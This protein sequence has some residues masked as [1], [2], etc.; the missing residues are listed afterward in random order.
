MSQTVL[1]TGGLG[2]IGLAVGAAFARQGD[3]LVLLDSNTKRAAQV[4]A[5][6]GERV[7]ILPTDVR[8]AGQV[9]SAVA[10]TL[11]KFG[12]I[13]YLV[14]CAGV[15]RWTPT[16]ELSEEEWD[17]VLDINLKG[18]FLVCREVG[19]AMVAAGQGGRIVNIASGLAVRPNPEI[20]HYAASKAGIIAFSKVLALELG[21]HQINV[22]CVAPGMVET[23]LVSAKRNPQEIAA[24]AARSPLGQVLQPEDVAHSVVF[25]CG[26][27]S[28]L[29]TG[30]TVFLN[31]GGL[32][33]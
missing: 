26:P 11:E 30:Q 17:L 25:L 4:Q 12:D 28:R 31:G 22:N 24:Y 2:D 27:Q 3:L 13:H 6:F 8:N 10:Q 21:P 23:Q 18:T 29:I 20:A 15:M 7:L 9:Q 14:N 32:M 16:L 1:I 5:E 19:R 33:P